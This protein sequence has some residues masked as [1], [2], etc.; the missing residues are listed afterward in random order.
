MFHSTYNGPV[1]SDDDKPAKLRRSSLSG[2]AYATVKELLLAGKRYAP[3]A[4]ISVEELSRELGVSRTP[5]WGAINRLEA[6]GIVEIAPRQGVYLLRF[7]PGRAL[8]VYVAREALEGT[9]ARLAATHASEHDVGLL[10]ASLEKQ[11]ACL[12]A[13][14]AEGYSEA[15]MAFHEHLAQ[16]AGNRTL[17]RLLD[18]VYAQMQA[19]RVR[20][21]YFP[22]KLPDSFDDHKRIVTAIRA[23]N[24]DLAER[25]ARAH[26][27][28]LREHMRHTAEDSP[29]HQPAR[30]GSSPS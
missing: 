14:D 9:V 5:V 7:D 6:E 28:T 16:A 24:G 26:I 20:L 18:L 21:K 19:M 30:W 3:G 13:G 17:E 1:K 23:R 8:D 15:A 29:V 11:S 4:K 22:T 27:Q 12:G 25:E 10:G 2:D